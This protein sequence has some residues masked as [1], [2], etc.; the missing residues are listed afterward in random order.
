MEIKIHFRENWL[1]F[2]GILGE[3]EL[4]LRILGAK[5]KYFQG[6][7]QLSFRDLGRSMHFFRDQG[8]TD[9]PGGPRH[10]DQA[11]LLPSLIKAFAM[12]SV[13]N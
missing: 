12:H 11:W 5:E 2:W 9:P 1:I 3:A 6:I 8:S 4:I 13:G 10:L 7:K